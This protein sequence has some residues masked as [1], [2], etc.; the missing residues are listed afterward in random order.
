MSVTAFYKFVDNFISTIVLKAIILITLVQYCF[1][2]TDFYVQ[3]LYYWAVAIM[4]YSM[5]AGGL[6]A[7]RY[8]MRIIVGMHICKKIMEQEK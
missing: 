1:I 8:Y 3:V 4:I 6:M 7:I 2:L 5:F